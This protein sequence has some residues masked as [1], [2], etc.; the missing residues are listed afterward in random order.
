M[1]AVITVLGKDMVGILANVSGICA[2]YNVNILD[3]SQSVLQDIFSMIMIADISQM[4]VDL[5]KLGDE[6]NELGLKMGL[7]IHVMH[8]DIF[9]TMHR[10]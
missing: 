4:S 2:L 9:N 3:V 1:K 5:T 7:R 10:I 6:M 8:E